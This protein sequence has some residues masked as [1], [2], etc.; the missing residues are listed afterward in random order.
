MTDQKIIPVFSDIDE[1]LSEAMKSFGEGYQDFNSK[2]NAKDGA[3]PYYYLGYQYARY[4]VNF[5]YRKYDGIFYKL[6][7]HKEE[8]R[9]SN[10]DVGELSVLI[11]SDLSLYV[12]RTEDL[13]LNRRGYAKT[14]SLTQTKI[15]RLI[16]ELPQST[17]FSM[18]KACD[19]KIRKELEIE[20]MLQLRK[21]F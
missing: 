5:I 4:E 1:N 7:S 11:N 14:R 20:F 15:G 6:P 2:L 18:I 16:N 12:D 19:W 3:D 8:T 17:P 13:I 9:L 10:A 21:R